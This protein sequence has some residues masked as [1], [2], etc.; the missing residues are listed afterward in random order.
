MRRNFHRNVA[1]GRFIAFSRVGSLF[2]ECFIFQVW[3]PPFLAYHF[4]SLATFFLSVSF[5]RLDDSFLSVFLSA[6][7]FKPHFI[8]SSPFSIASSLRYSFQ[9][10]FGIFSWGTGVSIAEY[11]VVVICN[12][13]SV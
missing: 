12:L 2:S 13:R 6:A 4:L 8:L 3:A 1:E 9:L 11:F 5:S 10:S 7:T